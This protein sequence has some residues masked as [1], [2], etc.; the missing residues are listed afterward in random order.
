MSDR[1]D[2]DACCPKGGQRSPT[3]APTARDG[4]GAP[5]Q[6]ALAWCL[7]LL[8]TREPANPWLHEAGA[9]RLLCLYVIEH[10]VTLDLVEMQEVVRQVMLEYNGVL[11]TGGN[12]LTA[13]ELRRALDN[14]P[15]NAPVLYQRVHDELFTHRGWASVLLP[16][17]TWPLEPGQVE[18]LAPHPNLRVFEQDG[19]PHVE[20]SSEYV[21][22][23]GAYV[24][25][26][27]DGKLAVCVH[28][29]T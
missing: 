27:G 8:G 2:A 4:A 16:W 13:G 14:V 18:T 19:Q 15:D 5:A 11:D 21:P 7:R 1:N 17:D 6:A 26:T 24:T 22:A 28:A 12:T 3:A 25:R 20:E 29:H 9:Y 10:A 23:F